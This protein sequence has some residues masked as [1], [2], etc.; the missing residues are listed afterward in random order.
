MQRPYRF[1]EINISEVKKKIMDARDEK[2]L[3]L[4]AILKELNSFVIAFSGGV[5]STFLLYRAN[6]VRG[7]AIT[8]ITVRTPYIPSREI[9]EAVDFTRSFGINHKILD[10]GLPDMIKNNPIERCYLCKKTLFKDISGYAKENNY[11]YVVDGTNADD[12][13]DFRPGIAALKE[14]GI[15]SPLLES[16]LTKKDIR[17]LSRE[18]NLQIWDKPAMACLL[19]R[20]P[21]DTDINEGT[22]RQI[23][24]AENI[25]S[26]MG[27]P[28][29]RVRV[30]GVLA[31]IECIPEFFEEI[32]HSPEREHIISKLKK[33]GFRYV[34]LD[35]EGYRTGSSN[36]EKKDI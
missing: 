14:L 13:K 18:A 11:Q 34:S 31:R 7:S 15:R 27:Y 2:S 17:E 12:I 25:L 33:I 6:I 26:D 3:K 1:F 8:A 5:D 16:G 19:T 22:L 21:Y 20:I 10:I 23:E 35:L 32:I 36:P 4:D 24:E 28:G 29:T 30:H 9:D